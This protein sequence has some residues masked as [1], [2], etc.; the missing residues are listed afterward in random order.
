MVRVGVRV[1]MFVVIYGVKVKNDNI[2]YNSCKFEC[3]FIIQ[4][5][6]FSIRK[7]QRV[8]FIVLLTL[9]TI[10]IYNKVLTHFT[11][12]TVQTY[13]DIFILLP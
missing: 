5:L 1:A 4:F 2:C 10:N 9:S 8:A 7:L 11:S 6:E 3:L 12:G 13:I